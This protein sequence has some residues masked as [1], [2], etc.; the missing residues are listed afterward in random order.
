M[1]PGFEN[2]VIGMV[3]NESKTVHILAEDAYGPKY[4][5]I[6]LSQLPEDLQ[7]G[8]SLYRQ[9]EDGSI[10]EVTVVNISES[11][12]TLENANPLA[13]ENL[14]FNITLIQIQ[15]GNSSK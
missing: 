8:E 7:I 15:I 3:V 13:G 11:S 14:T 6:P 5:E 1:I 12:A 4:F 2:A 10:T 9:N